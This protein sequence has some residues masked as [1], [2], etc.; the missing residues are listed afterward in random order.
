MENTWK[1]PDAWD[2]EPPSKYGTPIRLL[3]DFGDGKTE[4][5][6]L[7]FP[8]D[9]GKVVFADEEQCWCTKYVVGWKLK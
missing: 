7:A 5:S 6:G 1:S 3:C 2:V 4:I 8:L 9:S